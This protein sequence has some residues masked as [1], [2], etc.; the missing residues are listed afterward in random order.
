MNEKMSLETQN[1]LLPNNL[2]TLYEQREIFSYRVRMN[3]LKYNFSNKY[4]DLCQCQSTLD[5]EHLYE[6]TLLN[7][8]M[9]KYE[10]SALYN[11]TIKEQKYIINILINNMKKH[12][13][14]TLAQD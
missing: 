3:K 13:E 10:Y 6:C 9:K 2:L 4:I 8:D 1:Y 12:E 7:S 5:N 14:F 11:G